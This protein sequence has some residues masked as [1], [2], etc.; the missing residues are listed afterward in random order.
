MPAA[1][2]RNP[3]LADLARQLEAVQLHGLRTGGGLSAAQLDW[4]PAPGSWTVGQCLEHIILGVRANAPQVPDKVAAA[5][6]QLGPP[7]YEPWKAGWIGGFLIKGVTPGSRRVRT[8][9]RFVP[10]PIT[11]PGV[12][13]RFREA[14]DTLMSWIRDADGLDVTRVRIRSPFLPLVTY[15]LGDCLTIN[16]LHAE[17]HLQ[18]ADRVKASPGFPQH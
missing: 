8:A 6:R 2:P 1:S 7:V 12:L 15:H 14:H 10:D 16:V 13:D 3:R 18:Q 4:P 11:G 9:N 17:R 5:K